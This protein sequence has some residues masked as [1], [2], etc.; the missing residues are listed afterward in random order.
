M[1]DLKVVVGEP[2]NLEAQ[3]YGFPAPEIKWF[4]DGTQIRPSANVNFI[5]LPDGVIGLTIDNVRPEDAGTY[6]LE[7]SNKLGDATGVSHVEVEPKEHKPEFVI[8]LQDASIVEGFPIKMEAK[9]DAHPKAHVKWN[10]NG[11]E[12]RPG[13]DHFK[14]S[15][16]PDGSQCLLIDKATAQD[17]GHYQVVATNDLGQT[18]SQA[19]LSVAPKMDESAPE[20]SPKF[21]SLLKDTSVDEGKELVLSA[22]FTANPLPEVIWTKNNEPIIPSERVLV[23]CDAK[24]VGLVVSPAEVGDAGIYSCLLANPLG[25]ESSK[26]TASVRKVYEK[27]VFAQKFV[28]HRM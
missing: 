27:P 3:V 1:N 11:E 14:V 24:S 8:E 12:I 13:G 2:L 5:N 26:C 6:T 9:I 10:H 4:K 15:E 18:G 25:E 7:V 22:P 21:I 20:E 23:T 19:V 17:A 16:Q 28:S